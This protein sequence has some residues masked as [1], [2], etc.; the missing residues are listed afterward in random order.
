MLR[1]RRD[2]KEAA[3]PSVSENK[4]AK[5]SISRYAISCSVLTG[6]AD[7]LVGLLCKCRSKLLLV[8]I[9]V[10]TLLAETNNIPYVLVHSTQ[11]DITNAK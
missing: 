4:K 3:D 2:F 11:G 8:E 9:D 1:I 5:G 6:P 7:D 10:R